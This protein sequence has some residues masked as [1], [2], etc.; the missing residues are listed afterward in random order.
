M[1]HWIH[2]VLAALLGAAIASCGGAGDTG[3]GLAEGGIGGTGISRGSVTGFGSIV[4]NGRHFEVESAEITLN[5]E[6]IGTQ[7]DLDVGYVVRVDGG[8]DD[9]IA[10]SVRFD[11]DVIGPVEGAPVLLPEGAGVELTV[12]QQTVRVTATTVLEGVDAAENV[13]DGT[14]VL[15]SGYRDSADVLV[16]TH[17]QVGPAGT[18]EQ[19]VGVVDVTRSNDFLING[20]RVISPEEPEVGERVIVRGDYD[21]TVGVQALTPTSPIERVEELTVVGSEIELEG[22]V[23]T[24]VDNSNFTV[25]GVPVDADGAEIVDATGADAPNGIAEDVEVEVEGRIDSFGILVA[26]RVEIELEDN[27][28]LVAPIHTV[29]DGNTVTFF[30]LGGAPLITVSVNENTRLRDSSTGG[31]GSTTGFDI[32]DLSPGDWVE[33]DGF[34]DEDGDVTALKIERIDTPDPV[35]VSVEGLVDEV[36]PALDTIDILG[37]TFGTAA[38]DIEDTQGDPIQLD[39]ISQGDIVEV[40]WTDDGPLAEVS[41]LEATQPVDKVE[42]E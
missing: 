40:T 30:T 4:V 23:D 6:T 41:F 25:D 29:P 19:I 28:E 24:F 16:A 36:T 13:G 10:D 11:A 21:P 37:V 17:L 7:D 15:V 38:A 31:S 20:L 26:Q 12:M 34:E 3:G 32:G 8:L 1:R 9:G 22:I 27:V 18:G 2:P 39:D 42:L 5:G 33:L 35:E 14:R